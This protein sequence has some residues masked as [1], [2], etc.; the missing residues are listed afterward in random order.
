MYARTCIYI[1]YTWDTMLLLSFYL[2][3]I[4]FFMFP[5]PATLP[6]IIRDGCK[7]T[8]FFYKKNLV[9]SFFFRQN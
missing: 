8:H 1:T 2:Y 5:K 4:V 7:D 3:P 9:L 6:G